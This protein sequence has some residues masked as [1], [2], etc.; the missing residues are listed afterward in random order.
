MRAERLRLNQQRRETMSELRE[1]QWYQ[2]AWS[3]GE[4]RLEAAKVR[5]QTEEW[6]AV[7]SPGMIVL[8]LFL[9][10]ANQLHR[11]RAI[12]SDFRNASE[13]PVLFSRISNLDGG[14]FCRWFSLW[15]A[16]YSFAVL[17][18]SRSVAAL[19]QRQEDRQESHSDADP[20]RPSGCVHAARRRTRRK[21]RLLGMG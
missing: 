13:G 18:N 2:S 21:R 9:H 14:S 16:P 4:A 1:Y 5:T 6:S 8:V 15:G 7:I 19:H 10:F 11:Y 17:R 20:R 12:V 3:Q